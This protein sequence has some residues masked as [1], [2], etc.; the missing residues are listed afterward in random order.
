[1]G[2]TEVGWTLEVGKVEVW[3]ARGEELVSTW[4]RGWGG[5]EGGGGVTA[6]VRVLA[7]WIGVVGGLG[8]GVVSLTVCASGSW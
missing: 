3:V 1:M 7:G 8:P 6:G 2:T 5:G 4:G